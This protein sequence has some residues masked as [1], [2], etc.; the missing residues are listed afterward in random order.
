MA[1]TIM[2]EGW[3]NGIEE[4]GLPDEQHPEEELGEPDDESEQPCP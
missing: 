1:L 4:D 2:P 3:E